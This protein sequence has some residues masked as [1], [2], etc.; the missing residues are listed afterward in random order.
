MNTT[1]GPLPIQP[2]SI[3]QL[4]S[5][6]RRAVDEVIKTVDVM[7]GSRERPAADRRH[8]FDCEDGMRLIVSRE[9]MPDG[10]VGVHMSASVSSNGALYDRLAAVKANDGDALAA[11]LEM[12]VARWETLS[13]RCCAGAE[14]LGLSAG[15]VPH[16]F[17]RSAH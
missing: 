12:A 5:R 9:Q 11:F 3:E 6:Y 16:W 7:Q 13:R 1:T 8:V 4:Q 2:E 14:F 10:A 15:L 17:E